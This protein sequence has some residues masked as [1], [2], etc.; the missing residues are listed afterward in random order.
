MIWFF[1]VVLAAIFVFAS[2]PFVKLYQLKGYDLNKF[3]SNI[4][5]VKLS[6]SG[7]NFIAFTKRL[8]R[9]L[10]VLFLVEF[11][12]WVIILANIHTFWLVF[13]DFLINLLIIP[14]FIGF[15]HILLLPIECLIKKYYLKKT[16][17]KLKNFKGIKIAITGSFGKTSTKN[18]L[19]KML[20][21][22]F[23][24]VATPKN[25]N[26]PMGLCKTVLESLKSDTQ[27]LIVEMGARHR[28]D[29][30]ELCDMVCPDIAIL[31][32]VG[33]Q[34]IET[35]G[36][37]EIVKKTKFELCESLT[38]DKKCYFD[39]YNENTRELFDK[40]TC[41]KVGLGKDV[42]VEVMFADGEGVNFAI[43]ENEKKTIFKTKLLGKFMARNIGLCFLVAK[44]LGVK[45]QDIKSVVKSLKPSPHRLEL[46]SRG[47]LKIID[48]AYNSNFDGF[49]E[50]IMVASSFKGEKV[51]V[52]PGMVELGER[53]YELN[54]KIGKIVATV[55]D[56]VIIMNK[57]NKIALKNGILS[58]KFDKNN[59][60]FADSRKEMNE[61]IKKEVSHKAVI[62]FEND[63]PDDYV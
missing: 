52:T 28:G 63:L 18:I 37:L 58:E 61:I 45:E 16:I 15:V 10:I 42:Y 24:V 14:L 1:S 41:K 19:T 5:A 21:T 8:I 32:S 38:K 46:I 3:F 35:F 36:S 34:H 59:M 17:K 27:I 43:S 57:T 33:E 51:L 29:I 4:F 49:C 25:F 6:L 47:D 11:F 44:D 23:K 26:T 62:L 55:F 7:K 54:F 30:K 22:K 12:I 56:K 9:F 40:A 50:A 20:A 48:D 53:Q 13:L 2:L 39:C 31:T 60:F